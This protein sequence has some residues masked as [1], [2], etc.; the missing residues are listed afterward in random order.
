MSK[1]D[2]TV[3][4][5]FEVG[6]QS[7]AKM[8]VMDVYRA[9]QANASKV[10][11]AAR[12][13]AKEQGISFRDAK[14]AIRGLLAEERRALNE[15]AAMKKKADAQA[16][17]EAAS[18][19]KA[20]LSLAAQKSRALEQQFR[21]EERARKRVAE[22]AIRDAKRVAREELREAKRVAREKER[23]LKMQES[24]RG[25]IGS[26]LGRTAWGAAMGVAG[27]AGVA[28]VGNVIRGAVDGINQFVDKRADLERT[29]APLMA[30]GDNASNMK[31]VRSEIINIGATLGR[32]NEEVVGFLESMD[33]ISGSM[34]PEK[35]A[36]VKKESMELAELFG[37]DLQTA[38]RLLAKT[39]ITY[40]DSFD[41]MNQAQ[42]KML[43]IQDKADVSFSEMALR[44]PELMAN[45]KPLGIT[46]DEVGAAIMAT[47]AALGSAE[48]A[49]TGTRNA[50]MIIQDAEKEG[51][52]LT[53][54][55]SDKLSQLYDIAMKGDQVLLE[56]FK[57]DP[58]AAGATMVA[59]RNEIQAYIKDL[60]A[61]SSA[62]D[63]AADKIAQKFED[64]VYS[65]S[66]LRDFDKA[67][68]ENAPNVAADLNINNAM[69]RAMERFRAGQ[70]AGS[71]VSGGMFGAQTAFGLA[72]LFGND[73]V[74][75]EG[76]RMRLRMMP[77][78]SLLRQ[79]IIRDRVRYAYDQY[80][81]DGTI[82]TRGMTPEEIKAA[83]ERSYFDVN[84]AY[85]NQPSP[86]RTAAREA[87]IKSGIDESNQILKEIRDRLQPR[88]FLAVAK[89]GG[90]MTNN[91]E[92]R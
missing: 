10:N 53:G 69:T 3:H 56:L 74:V 43:L 62:E 91:T 57:R 67:I 40:G 20:R 8:T 70:V 85:A 32:T 31:Q 2:T 7:A 58:L 18:K 90:G 83:N 24:Q 11:E 76:N 87:D 34:S 55:L 16:E 30:L 26:L 75:D 89:P 28:G 61:M 52:R 46:F 71:V 5:D 27:Y 23:D 72:A 48:N 51:I 82:D 29:A 80:Q 1:G 15:E 88:D 45:A 36:E 35:M 47:T 77:E 84:A 13:L 9:Q 66:R 60:E 6:G 92:T 4:V 73:S 78:D 38:M 50:I 19:E 39:Q 25:A 49:F 14:N 63:L 42:N 81:S 64:P 68:I 21:D 33:S 44:M 37:T 54:T 86:E 17:A 41:S 22:E 79:N 12:A 65:A 59:K